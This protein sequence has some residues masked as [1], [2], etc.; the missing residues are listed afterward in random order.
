[1]QRHLAWLWPRLMHVEPYIIG[2]YKKYNNNWGYVSY[3]ERNTPQA[4][5]HFTAE[6]TK[7]RY[8][9]VGPGST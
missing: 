8:L 1:M 7:E 4:F 5:S 6:Y 2:D 3:D 9:V